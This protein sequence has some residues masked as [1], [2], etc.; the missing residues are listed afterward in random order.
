MLINARFYGKQ[1]LLVP[2]ALADMQQR[3]DDTNPDKEKEEYFL[4]IEE[5]IRWLG[6]LKILLD[7]E[8]LDIVVLT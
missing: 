5:T 7:F 1:T 8:A 6:R 2:S 4:A 3:F